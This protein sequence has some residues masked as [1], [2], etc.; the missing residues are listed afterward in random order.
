V[1]AALWWDADSFP[2]CGMERQE[3]AASSDRMLLLRMI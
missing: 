2:F 3:V 1:L